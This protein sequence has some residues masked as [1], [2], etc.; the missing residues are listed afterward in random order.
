MEDR[1]ARRETKRQEKLAARAKREASRARNALRDE[2][3]HIRAAAA[4]AAAA[5]APAADEAGTAAAAAGAAAAGAAAAR[6]PP[7]TPA[8]AAGSSGGGGSAANGPRVVLVEPFYGGSHRQFIDLLV[9]EV[10]AP[11]GIDVLTV[12][13]PAKKWHWSMRTASLCVSR[14]IPRHLPAG[15]TLLASSY[16]NLSELLALRPDLRATRTVL[17]FHENQ[18]TYPT[19]LADKERERDFQFGWIQVM[20]C[21]L[22]DTIAF[23]SRFN[24]HSFLGAIDGL[25]RRIPDPA[26]RILGLAEEIRSKCRVM[27]FPLLLCPATSSKHLQVE[28]AAPLP[29]QGS[30]A[31]APAAP[32]PAPAA[33]A[34]RRRLQILWNHRWEYDKCPEA[35]LIAL[36]R[37][38]TRGC[39][40]GVVMLGA[41]TSLPLP[42]YF[43][44]HR[45]RL[46]AN[47]KVDWWGY[48]DDRE[49]YFKL[50]RGADVAVSTAMHEFFGVA[51]LEAAYCGCYPLVPDS[52]VYPEIFPAEHRYEY[53]PDKHD[54]QRSGAGASK[55]KDKDGH[56]GGDGGG[57]GGVAVEALVQ[58][59]R[60]FCEDPRGVRAWQRNA[61]AREAL[62]LHRFTLETLRQPYAELLG[63]T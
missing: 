19:Q 16:L 13:L 47:G 57:D 30:S 15:A 45:R 55:S 58:R 61:Q 52:L 6:A 29:S 4:A 24:M 37:L 59:L 3:P 60:S 1:E 39:D 10:A 50:L 8:A 63:L 32:A 26:Q 21:M 20:S 40:F 49:H 22:A 43:E 35:F 41:A 36:E 9:S 23:N 31:A 62:G 27:Y 2:R 14:R 7:T 54:T 34:Q 18:L 33:T 28:Q 51:M 53:R 42:P 5:A 46:A 25:M 12:T 38:E 11:R 48:A 44:E 17:Y 56:G